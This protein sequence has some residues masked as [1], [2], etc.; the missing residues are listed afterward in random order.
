MPA[1]EFGKRRLRAAP[2][3]TATPLPHPARPRDGIRRSTLAAR[4]HSLP[5]LGSWERLNLA[6]FDLAFAALHFG[7]F[8]RFRPRLTRGGSESSNDSASATRC[9]TGKANS[10][11]SISSIADMPTDYFPVCDLA[12]RSGHRFRTALGVITQ[13]WLA[14]PNCSPTEW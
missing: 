10:V 2:G 13:K 8:L 9:S 4:V 14:D 7:Q 6:A 12:G 5:E 11:F 1:H 3:P